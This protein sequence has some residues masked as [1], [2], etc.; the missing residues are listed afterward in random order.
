V[1]V[2]AIAGVLAVTAELWVLFAW[3]A[4]ALVLGLILTHR[5]QTRL[6][7]AAKE[8]ELLAVAVE[9]AVL[10]DRDRSSSSR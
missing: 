3:V 2:F 10:D 4:S 6:A 8:D 7:E 5:R 1:V 9:R